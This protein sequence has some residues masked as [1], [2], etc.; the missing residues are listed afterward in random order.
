M[1]LRAAHRRFAALLVLEAAWLAG[2]AWLAC[3]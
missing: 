1:T 2:L 3:R